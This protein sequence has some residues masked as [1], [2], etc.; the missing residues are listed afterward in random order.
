M[1][2]GGGP[3]EVVEPD[4][5]PLVD[6]GVDFIV[7]IANFFGGLLFLHGLHLGGGAVFVSA[8][9]VHHV[10]AL[11]LLEARE[12]VGGEDAADD[13]SQMWHVVDVG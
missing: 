11:Q 10:G 3:S 7:K 6:L 13:V 4:I 12:D 9:D 5:E 8:A 2:L 1:P